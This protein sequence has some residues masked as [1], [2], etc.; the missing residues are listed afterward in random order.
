MSEIFCCAPIGEDVLEAGDAELLARQLKVLAEPARLRIVSMLAA[1]DDGEVC[2]CDITQPLGLSQPTV[3]HH[4]KQL[5]EAGFVD[6]DK[7]G[8]WV[9]YRLVP[10]S[11]DAVREALSV[12]PEP[13]ST[14]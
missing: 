3:S 9:Y 8:K 11:V 12:P 1:A 10:G 4:M 7:R 14:V 5:R 13:A 6:G 2:V